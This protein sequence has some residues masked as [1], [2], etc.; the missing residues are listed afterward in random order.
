MYYD[1]LKKNFSYEINSYSKYDILSKYQ[2]FYV[3]SIKQ[4]S[5]RTV[6]RVY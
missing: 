2:P 5:L 6:Y 1:S 4:V 3:S